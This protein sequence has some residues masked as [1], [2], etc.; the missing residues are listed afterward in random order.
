MHVKELTNLEQQY[1]DLI[2]YKVN[3]H[4]KSFIH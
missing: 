1:N 4:D 2:F 3:L